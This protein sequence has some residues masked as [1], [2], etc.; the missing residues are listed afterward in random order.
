MSQA[1]QP[2]DSMNLWWLGDAHAPQ[3]IG[4][5]SLQDQRRKVALTY[6]P[7]WMA[8]PQGFALSEDLPLQVG[9]MLP[10]A[11]DTAA[12][13]VDDARPDQ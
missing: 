8:S 7:A 9:L 3:R 5:L 10:E 1:Y 2:Q 13:A 4:T 11:R 6:D 12:G